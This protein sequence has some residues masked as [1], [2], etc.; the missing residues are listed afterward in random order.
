MRVKEKPLDLQ[1]RSRLSCVPV[2]LMR[3][4]LALPQRRQGGCDQQ[5]PWG[6]SQGRQRPMWPSQET[7]SEQSKKTVPGREQKQVHEVWQASWDAMC[8]GGWRN[9]EGGMKGV[10]GVGDAQAAMERPR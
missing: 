10:V 3:E 7:C 5:E 6:C 4:Y 8:L 2:V 9:P 1:E